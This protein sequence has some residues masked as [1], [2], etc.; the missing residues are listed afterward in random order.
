[1][2]SFFRRLFG[3]GGSSS[4]RTVAGAPAAPFAN[5]AEY[6]RSSNKRL[7]TLHELYLKYKN[8]PHGPKLQTVLEQTKKI[9][10]YLVTKKRLHE[11]ELFHL[12]HTDHFI[13]TFSVIIEVY[14]RHAA[15]VVVTTS[16]V[17][18]KAAAPSAPA[19][20]PSPSQPRP[21]VQRHVSQRPFEEK[22]EDVL[23]KIESETIR[24][25]NTAHKVTEMVRR[26]AGQAPTFM[27]PS[28]AP[29]FGKASSLSVPVI[30][31]DTFSRIYYV[32]ELEGEG[33]VRGE[34]GYTSTDEEKENF[35][36]HIS[37]RLGID[38]SL[39]TYRGN[40]ILAIPGGPTAYMPVVHWNDCAYVIT[41][42]DYRLFPVKTQQRGK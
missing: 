18:Q 10:S 35:L 28:P 40:T 12:Q 19:P 36:L 14:L 1:M 4:Y 39:L 24:G 8:T 23:R 30:A 22:V 25:I 2:I 41:M 11:L 17:P 26:V 34:I 42:H 13:N 20:Q 7:S 27:P 21:K 37:S 16:P 32:R 29:A 33:T 6:L 9:H 5:E 38:R 3:Y 31:I 15:P